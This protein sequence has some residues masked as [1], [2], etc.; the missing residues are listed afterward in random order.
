MTG[1]DVWQFLKN[2]EAVLA[3]LGLAFVVKMPEEPPSP[4]NK[5]PIIVWSW[6]WFREAM[7]TF[8]NFRTPGNGQQAP[9]ILP[10]TESKS[11][12]AAAPSAEIK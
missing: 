2:N 9:G 7:L 10:Q 11:T 6:H 1:A 3:L 4:F 12:T 5:V 8:V